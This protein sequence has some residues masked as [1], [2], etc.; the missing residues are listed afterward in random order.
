MLSA[1]K[2]RLEEVAAEQER[3]SKE[4]RMARGTKGPETAAFSEVQKAVLEDIRLHPG[5]A[6]K[7]IAERTQMEPIEITKAVVVLQ[8]HN[9]LVQ[10]GRR[11]STRWFSPEYI[12]AFAKDNKR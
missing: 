12:A 7:E 8:D 4:L 11:K 2:Q 6:R 5:A 10:V 1:I 9:R 3:L